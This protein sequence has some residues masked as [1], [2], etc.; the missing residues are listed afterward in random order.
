MK[1]ILVVKDERIIACDIRNSLERSGYNVPAIVAYGEHAIEKA[2]PLEPDLILMDDLY[3]TSNHPVTCSRRKAA[4]T[5]FNKLAHK[6]HQILPK[7]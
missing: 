2:E 1:N 4:T 5:Y 6:R 7:R 3:K